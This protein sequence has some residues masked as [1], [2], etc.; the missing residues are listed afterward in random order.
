MP[1]TKDKVAGVTGTAKPYVERALHDAELREHVK[2]A[3]S[4]ARSIYDGL[5]GP[6]GVTG[7]AA[8]VASDSDVHDNLRTAVAELRQAAN[9]LQGTPRA[10]FRPEAAALCR[11]HRRRAPQSGDRPRDTALG[12]EQALRRRRVRLR[13]PTVFGQ[14]HELAQRLGAIEQGKRRRQLRDGRRGHVDRRRRGH[15][16]PERARLE[17]VR[18]RD[19]ARLEQDRARSRRGRHLGRRRARRER[20]GGCGCPRAASIRRGSASG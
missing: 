2:Q 11:R 13:R 10:P 8:R 19:V 3:Y 16:P 6:R 18:G 4:A 1:N 7:L 14:R 17:A 20:R 5:I 9:R 12:E 15:R